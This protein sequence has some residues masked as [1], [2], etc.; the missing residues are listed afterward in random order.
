MT[1]TLLYSI[2][3]SGDITDIIILNVHSYLV[4]QTLTVISRND[5]CFS[6]PV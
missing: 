2:L 3:I 5:Y 6:V 1:D 4:L